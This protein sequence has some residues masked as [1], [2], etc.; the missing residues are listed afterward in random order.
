MMEVHI[1]TTV[2]IRSNSDSIRSLLHDAFSILM[3]P[4]EAA[5]FA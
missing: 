5:M 1:I 4:E 3:V 2:H